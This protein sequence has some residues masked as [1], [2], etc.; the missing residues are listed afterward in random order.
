MS[1]D[2]PDDWDAKPVK[3]LVGKNFNDVAK[4]K[5]KGVFVEFCKYIKRRINI[6]LYGTWYAT[7]WSFTYVYIMIIRYI[8]FARIPWLVFLAVLLHLFIH[9]SFIHSF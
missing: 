9:L 5:K 7:R 3:V 6:I 4:D 8:E 1:E 2:I